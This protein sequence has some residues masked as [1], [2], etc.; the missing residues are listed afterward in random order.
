M[1]K[2]FFFSHDFDTRKDPKVRLMFRK[3][4]NPYQAYGIYWAIL[5]MLAHADGYE[6][7]VD[8]DD[9]SYEFRKGQ[10]VERSP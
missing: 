9:I 5:E 8:Y 6:L 3:D 4:D 10:S 7:D 1:G 2:S